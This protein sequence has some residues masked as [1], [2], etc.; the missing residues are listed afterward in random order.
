M[1]ARKAHKNQIDRVIANAG[2][3]DVDTFD[4]FNIESLKKQFEVNVLA[5]LRLTKAI[6]NNLVSGSKIILVSTRVASH[7]DN[8]SGG[9]YGYRMSKSALNMVGINLAHTLLERKIG[10]FMLHPG[11]V[12]TDL[13]KSVRIH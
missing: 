2:I 12:R 10:V 5:P 8:S 9:E 3:W 1:I 13:T 6:E 11:F 4:N 7:Q